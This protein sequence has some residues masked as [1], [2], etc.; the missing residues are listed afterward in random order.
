MKSFWPTKKLKEILKSF[1]NGIW[2]PEDRRNGI[3]ILR[4][5]NFN[6][7]G[8][9]NFNDV[10][11]RKVKNI[12]LNEKKLQ[13]GDI[14][15]ERSG[16]GPT[17]P[18]G[19]V[20]YFD[21]DGEYYFGNFITRFKAKDN[22][23]SRFLFYALF[24]FHQK[25]ITEALQTQTTNIRNLKFN[26]YLNLEIPL[27]PLEI[28][29]RIVARIEELFEKI[30]KA[31]QLRAKAI[32]ETEKIF[33]SALQEIFDKAEKKWGKRK[34]ST[35]CKVKN[36]FAFKSSDFSDQGIP[37]IRI[38][39]IQDGEIKIQNSVKLPIEFLKKYQ[40]FRVKKGDILIAMSGATTGKIGFYNLKTPALLNQ[41]VGKFEA[42]LS[43]IEKKYLKLVVERIS[44]EILNKALGSA[45]PNIS[46]SQ[47]ENFEITLPPL[48][49]QKKI[50][51]YLD[52][53]KEKIE[54]LKQLQQKQLEELNEL[55]N[56]ILEKAFK[57]ELIK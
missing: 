12:N 36:G 52:D 22:V 50:V 4:S 32:E 7:D 11:L 3:R 29:K 44:N 5:T 21:A 34:L 31:K 8:T 19:R 15:L 46:A 33:Q 51:A 49:E 55:K 14:L 24:Y 54:K 41:R 9:I 39:N 56:S 16:G 40:N 13:K 26:E 2:G 45:Q 42:D 38:S 28:Q 20:V 23:Y 25:G 47:I 43:K 10:A 27:P 57:G 30:D 53:L 37:L 18:V 48:S 17:Q 35:V 1:D 6:N